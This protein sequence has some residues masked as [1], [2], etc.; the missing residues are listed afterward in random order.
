MSKQLTNIFVT[1]PIYYPSADPHIGHVFSTLIADIINRYYKQRGY[2][3]YFITGTD[4][5]GN[6]ILEAAT[7]NNLD[8]QIFVDKIVNNFKQ[9]WQKLDIQYDCF[10]RTT[11]PEH[12]ARVQK[13]FNLLR[14]NIYLGK[15]VGNYCVQCEENYNESQ[16]IQQDDKKFCKF[17]HPISKIEANSYF[18]KMSEYT[19]W[20]KNFLKNNKDIIFPSHRKNELINT[21]LTDKL[22]DLSITRENLDWGICVPNDPRHTIYV[23]IDAL[24]NYITALGFPE[25]NDELFQKFWSSKNVKV[26]QLMSKEIIRFHGIYWPIL[27]YALKLPIPIQLIAHGWIVDSN[28]TKMSKS[29]GNA[30]NPQEWTKKIPIDAIRY[31]LAKE[32]SLAEDSKCSESALIETYNADLVNKL[33]NLVS[34]VNVMIHKFCHGKIPS[35][36]DS[37]IFQ[38]DEFYIKTLS[39]IDTFDQYFEKKEVGN[40]IKQVIKLVEAANQLIDKEQPW[41]LFKESRI[42]KLERHLLLLTNAIRIIFCLLSPILTN[43]FHRVCQIMNFDNEIVK[44]DN[45]KNIKLI[46]NKKIN[47]NK[48][49][50]KRLTI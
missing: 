9:L 39:T 35:L 15:W 26:I 17:H 42:N 18:F 12:C 1:T 50:Y 38:N 7:K 20:I 27:L 21:F 43:G 8:P 11:M 22:P 10:W 37:E 40:A 28:N 41:M 44:W 4:E 24:M 16:I 13:I 48:I 45:I 23:W 30:I 14:D 31:Y 32:I 36:D 33:G 25:E 5:H 46:F 19:D 3:T 49:L 2:Q 29:L 47:E 34:R 6:K